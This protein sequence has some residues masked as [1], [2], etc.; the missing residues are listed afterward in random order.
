MRPPRSTFRRA[1]L[2]LLVLV[3]ALL[4]GACPRGDAPPPSAP[5]A[6]RSAKPEV[7]TGGLVIEH[8]DS[9]RPYFHDFG[10]VPYGERLRHVFLL[11][12]S[13]GRALTI[14][15]ML[16]SCGCTTPRVSYVDEHGE[17]VLGSTQRGEQVI[18]LPPDTQV[19]IEVAIDTTLVET[20]NLD[21]LSQVRVRTDSLANPYLTLELHLRV[22]KAFRAVPPKLE[23]G[24]T[25]QSAGKSARTDISTCTKN[26]RSRIVA[27]ESVEGTF[28][29]DLQEA[30]AHGE[31]FWI[32][33]A[34][35]PPGLP[36]GPQKGQVILSTTGSDGTGR[37]PAFSVPI[38]AQ[39]T[40][41][42]LVVPGILQLSNVDPAR[43]AEMQAELVALVPGTQLAV[44]SAR[45]EGEGSQGLELVV[46][47]VAPDE[48]QR[49]ARFAV[50]FRAKPGLPSGNFR[51]TA[52][53][54]T[55]HPDFARVSVPYAGSVR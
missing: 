52:I 45:L 44:R 9:T 22:V 26:D 51:G 24:F 21:K 19:E 33:V 16:P 15:D 35:A 37:G 1:F 23:L 55:D 47:P 36:I 53:F 2:P 12:N 27:I 4:T 50:V 14:Q 28:T 17:R 8:G 41:D 49:A 3:L 6:A 39:I 18:T 38:L 54:E 40:P 43:G 13:E 10:D 5:A 25:P 46:E 30:T 31:T 7:G 34:T 29:A 42:V 48:T 32:L 20:P 11:K